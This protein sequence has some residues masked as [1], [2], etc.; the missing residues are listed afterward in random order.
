MKGLRLES[1]KLNIS[2]YP[3]DGNVCLQVDCK[4]TR[5]IFS[6]S[7]DEWLILST[8]VLEF[9]FPEES[10]IVEEHLKENHIK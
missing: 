9:C 10:A 7:K 8:K 5:E 4:K 2:I 3:K 1:K 6:L